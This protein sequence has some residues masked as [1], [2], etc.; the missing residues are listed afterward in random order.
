MWCGRRIPVHKKKYMEAIFK[1]QMIYSIQKGAKYIH[2]NP[3]ISKSSCI[4]CQEKKMFDVMVIERKE[5]KWKI[6]SSYAL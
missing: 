6:I 3:E 4:F 5:K 1:S 2:K